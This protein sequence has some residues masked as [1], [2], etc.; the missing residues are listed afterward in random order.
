MAAQLL[1][2]AIQEEFASR[3]IEQRKQIK[4]TVRKVHNVSRD[5]YTLLEDHTEDLFEGESGD[6]K[7]RV[8]VDPER[9]D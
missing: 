1:D 9:R 8:G 7:L 3:I 2:E 4:R 5:Q 6:V